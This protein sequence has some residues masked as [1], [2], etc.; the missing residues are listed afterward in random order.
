MR[1][2]GFD[3]D[4]GNIEKCEKHGLARED[5]E[6]FF[7]QDN[8]YVAP[9]IEHSITES[10]FFA[11]GRLLKSGRAVIVVFTIRDKEGKKLIRPISARFMHKKEVNRYEKEFEKN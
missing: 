7:Y 2:D 6:D 11:I 10:R 4:P 3:W 8:I 9:D 1:V 5:I